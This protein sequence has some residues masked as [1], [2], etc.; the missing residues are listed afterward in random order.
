MS[1]PE[2]DN[3]GQQPHNDLGSELRELG[4]Q[5]EHTVRTAL[6]GE[7]ARQIQ[8]DITAGVQE[9]G[10]QLQSAIKA[11][12]EDERIKQLAER[13][14]QAIIQARQSQATKDFQEALTRGISQ[15]NDQLAAFVT[16][17]Q[18][19]TGGSAETG[20]TTHLDKDKL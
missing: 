19:P 4:Q 6:E 7:R 13:G 20:D 1:Q 15:L 17:L 18:Q 11:I 14:Q 9:I 16:R 12:Q 5:L 10:T 2:G 8:S 3:S